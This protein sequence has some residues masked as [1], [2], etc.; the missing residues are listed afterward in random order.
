MSV[1]KRT[2]TTNGVT[3]EAWVV[4]YVDQQGHRHTETYTRK[5][6]ADDR[7][8]VIKVDV[9]KGVHTP[10]SRSITVAQAANDWIDFVEIEN[11][12]RSTLALYRQVVEKHIVPRVGSENIARLSTP[13]INPFLDD[14]LMTS[15]LCLPTIVL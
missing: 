10:S 6:D 11:R 5:K 3:K 2:W 14:F 8:A 12:E 1:R 4:D 13:R 15:T 7:H 9:A